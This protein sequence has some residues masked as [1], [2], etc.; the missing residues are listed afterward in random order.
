MGLFNFF[1]KKDNGNIIKEL[2]AFST[3]ALSSAVSDIEDHRTF[4]PFGAVLTNDNTLQ[5]VVYNDPESDT[6]DPRDHATIIQKIIAKKW[7]SPNV[8]LC[9]MAFDGISHL[10]SGDIDS[11]N[12]RVSHKPSNTHRLIS[13]TYK[14][15]EGKVEI[16]NLENPLVNDIR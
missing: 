7:E 16:L 2:I 13:Y 4:L 5:L 1:K 8:K 11:I 14:V 9:H 3:Q 15:V 10:D 12:V 6:I